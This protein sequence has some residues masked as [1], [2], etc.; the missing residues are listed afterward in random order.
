MVA[1]GLGVWLAGENITL[2]GI[3]AMLVILSGV[4]LVSLARERSK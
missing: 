1:V 4:G 3:L 2:I